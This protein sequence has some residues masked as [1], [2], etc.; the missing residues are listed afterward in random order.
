[1]KAL[2]AVLFICLLGSSTVLSFGFSDIGQ[3]ASNVG[4][5]VGNAASTAGSAV[6]NAAS[7]A[8]HAVA[9]TASN[10]G[11]AVGDAAVTAVHAVG[12]TAQSAVDSVSNAV[13][14]INS[15]I[16]YFFDKIRRMFTNPRVFEDTKKNVDRINWQNGDGIVKTIQDAAQACVTTWDTQHTGGSDS[17]YQDQALIDATHVAL[18]DIPASAITVPSPGKVYFTSNGHT[19]DISDDFNNMINGVQTDNPSK[20][21]TYS[22][23]IT[24]LIAPV[25]N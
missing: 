25:I 1:M 20:A 5:A 3:A 8:G 13:R 16:Q 14:D 17:Q 15:E 23:Q 6:G 24:S 2:L 12:N 7:T 10:I 19:K 4:S 21:A 9:N 22:F 11:S 18:A